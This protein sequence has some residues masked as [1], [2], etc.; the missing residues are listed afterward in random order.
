MNTCTYI[1]PDGSQC[2][3]NPIRGSNLCF[4][5]NPNCTRDKTDA[6]TKGGQNRKLY[7]IYGDKLQLDTPQDIRKLISETINGVWTGIIPA[8]QPA[9]TIGFLSRCFLDA[10]DAGELEER[11]KRLEEKVL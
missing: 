8:S 2:Q 1:K 10:Y 11:I 3:A 5:H 6:V 9:N 4:S 7:G